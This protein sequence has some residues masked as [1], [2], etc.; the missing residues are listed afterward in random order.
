MGTFLTLIIFLLPAYLVFVLVRFEI[1][2]RFASK[3]DEAHVAQLGGA[4]AFTSENPLHDLHVM[5]GEGG[6]GGSGPKALVKGS[7]EEARI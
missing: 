1:A 2:A 3:D 5:G 6:R 4:S 7:V